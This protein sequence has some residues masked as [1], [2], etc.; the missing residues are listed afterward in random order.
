MQTKSK[1]RKFAYFILSHERAN[2][3][4][5]YRTLTR[6]VKVEYPIYIIIDNEDSQKEL[7]YKNYPN[8]LEFDK[9]AIA[10]QTDTGDL[11][12]DRN[13]VIF[14]RNTCFDFA[15][16]LGLDYFLEL[17]DDYT[18]FVF[19]YEDGDSLLSYYLT[20]VTFERAVDY[21]IDFLE[22]SDA[23]CVAWAQ[24]GDLIGGKYSYMWRH[25]IRRKIM[26]SFFCRVD[27]PFKFLSRMNDDVTTYVVK[28]QRGAKFFTL[29]DVVV[30]QLE[31][32]TNRGGLTTMYKEYGTYVKSFYTIMMAPSCTKLGVVGTTKPRFHHRIDWEK[33]APKILASEYRKGD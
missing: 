29:R 15:N 21:T 24:S 33:C 18:D 1:G 20:Y 7:Y 12:E 25:K 2:K 26:N 14:A 3:V 10:K 22:K 4:L 8:I 16:K 32:Q 6:D 27:R 17:D 30:Q 23:D 28:D 31:T 13:S 5:T 9:K 11:I 19:R